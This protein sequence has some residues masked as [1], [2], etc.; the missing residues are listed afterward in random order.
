VGLLDAFQEAEG[1]I[2]QKKRLL[3]LGSHARHPSG[4]DVAR[5]WEVVEFW[6]GVDANAGGDVADER[7]GYDE[8]EDGSGHR[9]SIACSS[10]TR[11]R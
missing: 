9:C 7:S 2:Q 1:A 6:I 3:G 4:A 10:P 5:P 8:E 11:T